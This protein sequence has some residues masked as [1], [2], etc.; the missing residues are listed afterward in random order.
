MRYEKPRIAALSAAIESIQSTLE[1][2]VPFNPDSGMLVHTD[3]AY[4]ADE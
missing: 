4:E 2:N 1:K 3:P